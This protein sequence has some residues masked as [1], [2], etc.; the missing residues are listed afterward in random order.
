MV[1]TVM[2][3]GDGDG[4]VDDNNNMMVMEKV[5]AAMRT[6]IHACAYTDSIENDTSGSEGGGPGLTLTK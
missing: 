6:C 5:P 2:G 3:D 1:V 4:D